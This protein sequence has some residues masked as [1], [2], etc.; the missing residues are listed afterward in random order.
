MN[1]IGE[2]FDDFR[3]D[4][5]CRGIVQELGRRSG[6]RKFHGDRFTQPCAGSPRHRNDLIGQQ[7]SFVEVVGNHDCRDRLAGFRAQFGQVLLQC[8]ARQ[9][10]QRAEWFIKKQDR[11]LGYEGSRNCDALPHPSRQLP[12]PAMHCAR[13]PDRFQ[14]LF[15]MTLLLLRQPLR[16]LRVYS[17]PDILQRRKPRK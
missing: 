16:E 10:I 4:A 6:L 3:S 14:I 12:G 11:R 5:D 7:K 2:K 8:A 17:E 13:Q 15:R 9:R 1:K